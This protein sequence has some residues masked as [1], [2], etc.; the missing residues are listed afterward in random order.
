M[1]GMDRMDRMDRMDEI[2]RAADDTQMH[3]FGLNQ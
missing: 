2:N 1:D 3:E